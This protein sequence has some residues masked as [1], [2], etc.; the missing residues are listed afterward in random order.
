MEIVEDDCNSHSLKMLFKCLLTA[1]IFT[2]KIS[3]ICDWFYQIVS[4]SSLT[5]ISEL[6]SGFLY[7]TIFSELFI[8]TRIIIKQCKL[9]YYDINIQTIL[10]LDKKALHYELFL[11]SKNPS[12]QHRGIQRFGMHT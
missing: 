8:L 2:S 1:G 10:W 3:A 7:N 6:Q 9:Y 5:L 11:F 12:M 4:Q